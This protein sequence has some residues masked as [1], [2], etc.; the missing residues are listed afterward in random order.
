MLSEKAVLS[1]ERIHLVIGIL[2]L[3]FLLGNP[4]VASGAPLLPFPATQ[5]LFVLDSGSGHVLF[6]PPDGSVGV[7]INRSEIRALTGGVEVL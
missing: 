5:D 3:L 7:A 4:P 6:I 2:L 1:I